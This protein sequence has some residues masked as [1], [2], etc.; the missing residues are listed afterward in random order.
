MHASHNFSAILDYSIG[1]FPIAGY[2]LSLFHDDSHFMSWA[3][4]TYRDD[5]EMLALCARFA[6]IHRD[7]HSPLPG[8]LARLHRLCTR[9]FTAQMVTCFFDLVSY[10]IPRSDAPG[11]PE[12]GAKVVD[13]YIT[14]LHNFWTEVL[15]GR[16]D[17]LIPISQSV[18]EAYTEA[19][20]F[21]SNVGSHGLSQH[22]GVYKET[23]AVK[24]ENRWDPA[25][26]SIRKTLAADSERVFPY[27]AARPLKPVAASG[28]KRILPVEQVGAQV[29]DGTLHA[30]H[31][32]FFAPFYAA[33]LAGIILLALFFDGD[34]GITAAW[35]FEEAL[36]NVLY[37]YAA[38]YLLRPVVALEAIGAITQKD[39]VFFMEN[40]YFFTLNGE[41]LG[42]AELANRAVAALAAVVTAEADIGNPGLT[43]GFL[44][45]EFEWFPSPATSNF[46]IHGDWV[47]YLNMYAI[48]Q[49][50]RTTEQ[51][52]ASFATN[53]SSITSA[54]DMALLN[55]S[56]TFIREFVNLARD[57]INERVATRCAMFPYA[58]LCAFAIAFVTQLAAVIRL[59]RWYRW[60][61]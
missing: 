9:N 19:L 22:Y 59:W 37:P 21:F 31:A 5:F 26:R 42:I 53:E 61:F 8:I 14:S 48:Y 40:Y 23:M 54:Q 33:V 1:R 52:V 25:D 51:I 30:R 24:F 58:L 10:D 44:D 34:G 16:H 12:K 7:A 38:S 15:L 2:Y 13:E 57:L 28:A 41:A 27:I 6:S 17:R 46:S 45:N 47:S 39:L 18:N 55:G 20:A 36:A 43:S 56:L 60:V 11:F 50:G 3:T 4:Q 32:L 29:R 49:A 35:N